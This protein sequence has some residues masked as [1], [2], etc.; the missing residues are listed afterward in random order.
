[1]KGWYTKTVITLSRALLRIWGL[2]GRSMLLL[3]TTTEQQRILTKFAFGTGSRRPQYHRL[4]SCL[5]EGSKTFS[6]HLQTDSG[7]LAG[8]TKN[9]NLFKVRTDRR[10]RNATFLSTNGIVP[11]KAPLLVSSDLW[12][13]WI[14]PTFHCGR[15]KVGLRGVRTLTPVRI[16]S[17]CRQFAS[18]LGG[19]A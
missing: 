15:A 18:C 10:E 7:I 5:G 11:A 3:S 9:T 13:P 16:N 17:K 4:A 19:R 6:C 12:G 2:W 8:Q 14:A 1:M